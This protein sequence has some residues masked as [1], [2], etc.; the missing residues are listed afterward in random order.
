ME[1]YLKYKE[2][3]TLYYVDNMAIRKCQVTEVL[4]QTYHKKNSN[5]VKFTID[6][7]LLTIENGKIFFD[8]EFTEKYFFK[9][10]NELVS[11]LIENSKNI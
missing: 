3:D 2:G 4:T 7:G 9:T 6:Y 11:F 8:R 5:I 10:K 1:I